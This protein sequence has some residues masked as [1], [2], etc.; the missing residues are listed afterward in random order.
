MLPDKTVLNYD[1][2]KNLIKMSKTKPATEKEIAAE[3]IKPEEYQEIINRLGRHPNK[4]E[5]G[6]FGIMWSEH[7]C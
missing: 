5:L 4:A 3:G 2:I 7:C 6:M 1:K